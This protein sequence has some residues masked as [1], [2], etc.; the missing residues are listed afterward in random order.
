MLRAEA[1]HQLHVFSSCCLQLLA[2]D[3]G[4][5]AGR[6]GAVLR[7]G[8]DLHRGRAAGREP[9][10]LLRAPHGKSYS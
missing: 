9:A 4:V 10:G 1:S 3:G 8:G 6:A 2:A 5:A 7:G